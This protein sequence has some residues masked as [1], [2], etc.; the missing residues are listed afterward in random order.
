[1]TD[2]AAVEALSAL[3]QQYGDGGV[4]VEQPFYTDADG[5]NFG[6]DTRRPA[7]VK[8][9]LPD[10][11]DGAARQRRIEEGLWHLRAFDLAPIGQLQVRHLV[12]EDW[13]NAWKAHYH[14]LVIGRL[15]IK[16]SWREASPTANQ[17]VID[18]DQAWPSAQ[19]SIKLLVC[20]LP[21]LS[22]W[23]S[24]DG[25]LLIRERDRG[26]WPWRPRGWVLGWCW[27]VNIAE[28][29]VE[30]AR[31]NAER[32][33]V[34]DCLRVALVAAHAEPRAQVMLTDDQPQADLVLAN[35][36]A[37]VLIALAA[38]FAAA[39]RAGAL[40]IASGIIRDRADDVI[41]ALSRA[42]YEVVE[43]LEEDEWVTLVARLGV[44]D[45][46]FFVSP[47]AIAA[48]HIR[49]NTEQ[50]AQIARVLRLRAE[51]LVVVCDGSGDEIVAALR[52]DGRVP[53]AVPLE[54]RAGLP[55]PRRSVWLYQSALRGESICLAAAKGHGDW[56]CGVYSRT[57]SLHPAR[58]LHR[59]CRAVSRGGPGGSGTEWARTVAGRAGCL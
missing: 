32:N 53:W 21:R 52:Y 37:N 13:A 48:E 59:A 10:T 50:Q 54:R 16:P 15:L 31:L 51:E 36:I 47:A 41:V 40:L 18:L 39:S 7:I 27:R 30:A 5:A 6:I 43:R 14:P 12:E 1:V 56:D 19:V 45:I 11:L 23:Y 28:V 35:I 26:F 8:A 33:G 25:S 57:L 17:L 4:A 9:Y 38:E 29:A 2:L 22:G 3:F 44:R 55:P 20:V 58:G 49:F 46:V 42:S 24:R 34:S